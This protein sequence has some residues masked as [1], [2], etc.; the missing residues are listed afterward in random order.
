MNKARGKIKV[1]QKQNNLVVYYPMYSNIEAPL[2]LS[3]ALFNG[4]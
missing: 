4:I 2:R 1:T 3:E